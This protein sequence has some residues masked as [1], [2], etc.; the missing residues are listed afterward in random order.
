MGIRIQSN[1]STTKEKLTKMVKVGQIA[2]VN[3]VAADTDNYVPKKSGALRTQSQ[4]SSDFKA[5]SWNAPYA[6]KQYYN[7]DANFTT[8][9]TY[10]RWDQFAKSVHLKQWEKI[11]KG[12]MAKV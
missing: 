5:I 4:I 9:G 8:P 3:Q 10:A 2:L 6:R 1:L 11:I 7:V 12:A